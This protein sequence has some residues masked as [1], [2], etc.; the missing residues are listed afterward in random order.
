MDCLEEAYF[1]LVDCMVTKDAVFDLLTSLAGRRI[2]MNVNANTPLTKLFLDLLVSF[3]SLMILMSRIEERR[4]VAAL[5]TVA[6]EH[7]KG[8]GWVVCPKY[9]SSA[10]VPNSRHSPACFNLLS[11]Q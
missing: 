10:S 8:T 3:T 6:H 1:T 2:K 9:T 11:P 5:Y 4:T 7:C